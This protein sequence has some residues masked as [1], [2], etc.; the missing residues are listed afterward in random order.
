MRELAAPTAASWSENRP[1]P[2]AGG[3]NAV[4]VF[5]LSAYRGKTF[6]SADLGLFLA[7]RDAKVAFNADLY[8]AGYAAKVTSDA[9]H[10]GIN[11][12]PPISYF[13][14]AKDAVS[15]LI[16]NDFLTPATPTGAYVR[17]GESGRANLLAFLNK[18][19]GNDFVLLRLSPDARLDALDAPQLYSLAAAENKDTFADPM[20]NLTLQP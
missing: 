3:R 17:L 9:A 13:E 7:A 15:T 14:G 2:P 16:Q 6:G 1:R 8:A 11:A 4:V 5:D 19:G 12:P 20:L 10:G 18:R